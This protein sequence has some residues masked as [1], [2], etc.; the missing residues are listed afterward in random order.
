MSYGS[1]AVSIGICQRCWKKIPYLMLTPDG[2]IP[3]LL[4]CSPALRNGC[5]D[6]KDPY[7]LPARQPDP[8]ALRHA[9]PDVPLTFYTNYICTN[10]YDLMVLQ[11][12][13]GVML[14]Y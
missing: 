12:P 1:G 2:D 10:S 9:R 7:K 8:V 4:V 6:N 13:D 5:W 3:G 14:G 11:G